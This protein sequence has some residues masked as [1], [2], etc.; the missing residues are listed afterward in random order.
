[1][2]LESLK[3]APHSK[4][5]MEGASPSMGNNT[6]VE[7]VREAP[8][9]TDGS[10]KSLRDRVGKDLTI[11]TGKNE[12]REKKEFRELS[13]SEFS[14]EYRLLGQVMESGHKGMSIRY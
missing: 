11:N 8:R 9:A 14:K 2:G 10:P 6:T 5:P 4:T 12:P 1:M 7:S 3:E 13:E